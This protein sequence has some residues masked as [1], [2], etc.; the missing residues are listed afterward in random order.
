[1][2][3]FYFY[4]TTPQYLKGQVVAYILKVFS[5][6]EETQT[7]C[8]ETKVFPVRN[9]KKYKIAADEAE[10]YGKLVVADLMRNEVQQ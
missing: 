6:D 10:M 2:S 4:T 1:M 5:E 8:L 7:K 3:Y 9:S